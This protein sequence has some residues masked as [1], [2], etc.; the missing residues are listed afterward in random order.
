MTSAQK[1]GTGYAMQA[2]E[3]AG[4]NDT[5]CRNLIWDTY[6]LSV[7]RPRSAAFAA[8]GGEKGDAA[9]VVEE[10]YRPEAHDDD[11][12]SRIG[13]QLPPRMGRTRVQKVHRLAGPASSPAWCELRLTGF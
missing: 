12:A 11:D 6:A 10:W 7:C 4:Q 9:I 5:G 13:L 1:D 3:R 2:Y 8:L